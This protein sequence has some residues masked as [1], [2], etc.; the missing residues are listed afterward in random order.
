M[1]LERLEFEFIRESEDERNDWEYLH[2]GHVM[3]GIWRF[4]RSACLLT[5]M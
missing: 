3:S 5:P 4:W 2:I 1:A